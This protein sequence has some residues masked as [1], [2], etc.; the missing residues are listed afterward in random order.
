VVTADLS[1][2]SDGTW[3]DPS[4]LQPAAPTTFSAQDSRGLASAVGTVY[5]VS[6]AT[7]TAP[8]SGWAGRTV[9]V[10]GNAGSAPVPVSLYAKPPG[11]ST[12]TLVRQ[13]TARTSGA[14]SV[15]LP[16]PAS[17]TAVTLPWRITTDYGPAVNGFVNVA[18][19]FAPTATGPARV[20]Y[21]ARR[22]LSGTAVPGDKVTVMTR[23]VGS[24]TWSRAG[25]VTASAART[26]SLVLRFT[27]DTVW[28]ATSAS[29]TSPTRKTVIAPTIHAPSRVAVRGLVH[30]SGVALPGHTLTL[31]RQVVGTTTWAVVR[32][33]GVS[34]TGA[35]S[36]W[37]RQSRSLRFYVVSNAQRSRTVTV[38]V[39]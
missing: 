9:T 34:R 13:V 8:T 37:R 21:G 35:W 26:W 1:V 32:R 33:L 17:P 20:G 14:F 27:R 2:G 10:T 18:P 22:T 5:P 25:T 4:P 19:T 6:A 31:Y 16:L 24:R 28:R 3:A 36:N 12:F 39:G 7:A 38:T 11:S 29:G 30:L 15:V 23:P